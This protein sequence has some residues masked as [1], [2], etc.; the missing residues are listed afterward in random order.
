MNEDVPKPGSN[1]ALDPANPYNIDFAREKRLRNLFIGL[2]GAAFLVAAVLVALA[3]LFDF[4]N[5][6]QNRVP[7][8]EP[9]PAQGV[10]TR[11]DGT[12]PVRLIA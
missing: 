8:P 2:I 6:S 3:F 11:G 12:A 4:M 5:A 1:A 10:Q 7:A 9:P